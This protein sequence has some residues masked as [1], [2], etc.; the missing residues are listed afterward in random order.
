M[1]F[2]LLCHDLVSMKGAGCCLPWEAIAGTQHY[3][4]QQKVWLWELH[5]MGGFGVVFGSTKSSQTKVFWCVLVLL[6][7]LLSLILLCNFCSFYLSQQGEATG[8]SFSLVSC[9]QTSEVPMPPQP[10]PCGGLLKSPF[11]GFWWSVA[12]A[13]PT[14]L[15]EALGTQG[16]WKGCHLLLC[17]RYGTTVCKGN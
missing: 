12:F 10:G 1:G 13:L 14:L 9:C 5:D 4:C 11:S 2:L 8:I 15:A 7:S 16:T 17:Q 6:F 3:V